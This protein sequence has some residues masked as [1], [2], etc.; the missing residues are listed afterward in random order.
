MKLIMKADADYSKSVCWSRAK[1]VSTGVT[2]FWASSKS[3]C[4]SG[5]RFCSHGKQSSSS[6]WG[7]AC[8]RSQL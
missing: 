5:S 2:Y 3:D 6:S 1:T 8:F 7:G 4:W